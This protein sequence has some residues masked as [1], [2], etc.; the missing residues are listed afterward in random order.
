MFSKHLRDRQL[1]KFTWK[2][3]FSNLFM[4]YKIVFLDQ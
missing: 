4:K 2:L 1:Y 3:S